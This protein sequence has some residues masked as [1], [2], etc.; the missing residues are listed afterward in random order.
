MV[1]EARYSQS[2]SDCA[3]RRNRFA[4]GSQVQGGAMAVWLEYVE[5][6]FEGLC[7]ERTAPLRESAW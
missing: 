1:V 2:M 4:A 6:E 5:T 7:E 3:A